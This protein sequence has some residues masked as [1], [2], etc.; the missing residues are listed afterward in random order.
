[1]GGKKIPFHKSISKS[2]IQEGLR[3]WTLNYV[4][5]SITEWPSLGWIWINEIMNV[6]IMFRKLQVVP[7]PSLKHV[8][9]RKEFCCVD[10]LT[11][12]RI[13]A[14]MCVVLPPGAA[15]KSRILSPGW[16]SRTCVTTA[17]GKFCKEKKKKVNYWWFD[18]FKFENQRMS[19]KKS[20][21][22]PLPRVEFFCK[23]T[24]VRNSP[25]PIVS[26]FH[27]EHTDTPVHDTSPQ[28]TQQ[29]TLTVVLSQFSGSRHFGGHRPFW[30]MRNLW[31]FFSENVQNITVSGATV[32][33]ALDPIRSNL[34]LEPQFYAVYAP[35]GMPGFLSTTLQ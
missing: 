29:K 15:H 20:G 33:A 25:F 7:P 34:H 26:W 5:N 3:I 17:E 14:A 6:C 23:Y 35:E 8:I 32:T 16:G 18:R 2:G 12:S 30:N 10:S 22:H 1:M 24:S 21:Q 19:R 27:T 13:R 4:M 28:S 9:R 31:T 11:W